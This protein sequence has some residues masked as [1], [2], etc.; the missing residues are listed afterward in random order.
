VAQRVI[1]ERRFNVYSEL[2]AQEQ[3]LLQ[4]GGPWVTPESIYAGLNVEVKSNSVY[5]IAPE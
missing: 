2:K 5:V 1:L 3:K 4:Y